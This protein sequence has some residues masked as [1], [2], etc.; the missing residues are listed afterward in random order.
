LTL[1]FL[2]ESL[3]A[4]RSS[5]LETKP[6]HRAHHAGDVVEPDPVADRGCR[7]HGIAVAVGDRHHRRQHAAQVDLVVRI[8]IVVLLQRQVL[9]DA[10]AVDRNRK[11]R[12][13]VGVSTQ[14]TTSVSL[15]WN[16]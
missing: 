3:P 15:T 6:R 12:N 5:S 16:R 13:A 10:D 7:G 8:G 1:S 2:L 4:G 11:G 9:R 14:P